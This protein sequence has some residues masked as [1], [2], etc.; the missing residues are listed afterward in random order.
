MVYTGTVY[1]LG[2][3]QVSERLSGLRKNAI[4]SQEK[5]TLLETEMNEVLLGPTYYHC[6]QAD[7]KTGTEAGRLTTDL[8][9]TVME[10]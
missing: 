10:L 8:R 9:K 6:G 1:I 7:C 5:Q 4:G 3:S 2:H